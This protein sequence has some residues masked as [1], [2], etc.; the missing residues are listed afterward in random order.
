MYARGRSSGGW[1]ILHYCLDL[2]TGMFRESVQS[3]QVSNRSERTAHRKKADKTTD[4]KHI[5]LFEAKNIKNSDLH[6][7]TKL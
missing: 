4:H 7:N 5:V 3:S 6:R 1:R 2:K